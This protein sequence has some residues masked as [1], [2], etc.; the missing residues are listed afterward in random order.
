[1]FHA[2]G[3]FK[4]FFRER[5]LI[6]I[7]FFKLIFPVELISSNLSAKNDSRGSRACYPGKF[8][9]TLHAAMAI[10][11]LF[12]QFLEKVC[13]I[14]GPNFECLLMMHFVCTVSIMYDVI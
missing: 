10:L 1:M 9:E 2:R 7:T 6:F 11:V 3:V 4:I 14:F 8:L 13:H 5:A 12:E